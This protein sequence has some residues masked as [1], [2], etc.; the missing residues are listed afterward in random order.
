MECTPRTGRRLL[1]L[2]QPLV[3][4]GRFADLAGAL[5]SEWPAERLSQLLQSDAADVARIAAV[6]LGL[7]GDMTACPALSTALHHADARVARAA[8]QALWNIWFRAAGPRARQTLN[9]IIRQRQ[10]ADAGAQDELDR[11]IRRHPTFAE[12]YHQRAIAHCLSGRWHEALRDYA[13][14][15]HLNPHHFAAKAGQGHC[16]AHLGRHA[17]AVAS[18]RAARQMHPRLEGVRQAIRRL[19]EAVDHRPFSAASAVFDPP[20]AFDAPSGIIGSI[21]RK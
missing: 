2:G 19:R 13:R 1:H 15:L 7:T 17:E 16:L 11:L 10:I 3:E 6:G 20:I 5:R 12:A 8:E 4:A 18:Y 21:A 9:A 14:A